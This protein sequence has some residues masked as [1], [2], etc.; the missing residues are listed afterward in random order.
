MTRYSLD[1]SGIVQG[2]GFRPYVYR[3][4]S[5][6]AL[7][8]FVCNTTAGVYVEIQGDESDCLAM[9]SAL[10]QSP[11]P[12]SRIDE[13]TALPIA[14]CDDT[15]FEI[16][17]SLH[18]LRSAFVS[19]DI[20]ICAEC[21]ADIADP[22]NR[23]YRYAFTN[24]TNC[25]PRF[26]IVQDI[27]YDRQNTT[28][29]T[30]TQCATCSTEYADPLNRRFHAQPNACPAC[31]PSL[32][33]LRDGIPVSG[34]PYALFY[35]CIAAG[36][37]VAIKGIGGYHLACDAYNDSAVARLR[38]RKLRYAK[39][40]AVMLRDIHTAERLCEISLQERELLTCVRKPVVLLKK[41]CDY[42]LCAGIAPDN[43]RLGVMLPYTPLHCIIMERFPALVM[44][45]ANVSDDPMAYQ[46]G[47]E[48]LTKLADAVLTHDRPIQ[49]RM[50]DSV[51]MVCAG[52]TRLLRRARGYVPEPV[53]LNNSKIILAMGAQQ[54]CTFCLA[55]GPNAFISGHM[56]EIDNMAA[57]LAYEEQIDDFIRIFGAQP[58]LVVRDM[59]PDYASS[60][61]A[62]YYG[63]PIIQVQHH[64]AHFAS[65]LAEH[66]L[67]G[68]ALGII[69]DGSGYGTD[70][71]VW[72]S[73]ALLGDTAQSVRIGHGIYSPLPGGEAAIREPWRMALS[74]ISIACGK[75]HAAA[76]FD[77]MDGARLLLNACE[78]R[79]NAPLTC[80]MG[81]LFDAV[82]AIAGIRTHAS[83]E[84]QAAIEL[85]K[86][87]DTSANGTYDI[88][89]VHEG[90]MLLFDWRPLIRAALYD[91]EH[92]CTASAISVR[93]H[94]ALVKLIVDICVNVRAAHGID[95][96]ALSGGVFQNAYLLENA[97]KQLKLMGFKVYTN[98][99]L[100]ANDGGISYGQAAAAAAC[101]N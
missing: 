58:E 71:N 80:G 34:D 46:D 52:E 88:A 92:G 55:K 18:G 75:E 87:L 49:R 94:R 61:R 84:G 74:M 45:S 28:M 4:A 44:T 81:R 26:T 40:F 22:S 6:F 48:A 98:G 70:G 76:F 56:G 14:P 86:A 62:D 66:G 82:A 69:F 96:I 91:A 27:P 65:V 9:L 42:A 100:P 99:M 16:R 11:P 64:H 30:F 39:P 59:H 38:M 101:Y 23:R 89:L 10:R 37:I 83:Y 36:G 73:E 17:E 15:G 5:R 78:A 3:L 77:T 25:G 41:R 51:C 1:I 93:M 68:A 47:D 8:G 79:I 19:P 29:R 21:A 50:D 90:D 95:T 7:C 63:K 35:D 12:A 32:L 43:A 72:G 67:S 31:G 20:G 97:F 13:V 57:G 54:K 33:F 24:C 60:R 85:E 53:R 2:V